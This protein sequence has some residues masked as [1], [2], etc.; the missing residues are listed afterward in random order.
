LDYKNVVF[1]TGLH[2]DIKFNQFMIGPYIGVG[3]PV[4]QT[5]WVDNLVVATGR[6]GDDTIPTK[7][8]APEGFRI[9]Q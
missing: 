5:F 1:R 4:N 8:R 9:E 3:S 7:P 6:N 2:P